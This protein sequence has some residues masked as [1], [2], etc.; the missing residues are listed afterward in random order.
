[1][2]GDVTRSACNAI[3]KARLRS[4]GRGG[5]F[6][7]IGRETSFP[8]SFAILY[9]LI[10]RVTGLEPLASSRHWR[11]VRVRKNLAT[12]CHA[13]AVMIR[14]ASHLL[15]SASLTTGRNVWLVMARSSEAHTT[16]ISPTALH[17][18][19]LHR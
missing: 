14:T 5:T 16:Q 7:T 1:M 4:S 17:A 12:L 15:L 8:T 19:C 9:L 11:K 10:S 6:T 18:I 2:P 3:S 13:L